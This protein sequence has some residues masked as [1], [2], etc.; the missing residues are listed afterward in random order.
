MGQVDVSVRTGLSLKQCAA[1]F[2]DG[3]AR[4]RGFGTLVGGMREQAAG[5][6]TGFFTPQDHSA[7]PRLDGADEPDFTLGVRVP[8]QFGMTTSMTSVHMYVWDR[9]AHREVA[10]LAPYGFAEGR[11]ANKVVDKIL[12]AFRR[13]DPGATVA[14]G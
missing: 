12:D 9:Q 7:F 11:H 5:N 2:R 4:T 13:H 10:V 8:K 6:D 1:A 14:R 3:A